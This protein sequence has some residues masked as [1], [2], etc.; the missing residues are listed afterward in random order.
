MEQTRDD[1]SRARGLLRGFVRVYAGVDVRS[2]T[3]VALIAHV[4]RVEHPY[5]RGDNLSCDR[6]RGGLDAGEYALVD[7]FGIIETDQ[8][9]RGKRAPVLRRIDDHEPFLCQRIR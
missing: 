3:A 1:T 5:E 8:V 4:R 9:E 6:W 2:D 7:V